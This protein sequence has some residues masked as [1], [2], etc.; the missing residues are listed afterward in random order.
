AFDILAPEIRDEFNLGFQGLLTIIAVVAAASLALQVPIAGFADRHSRV[1]LAIV[2]AL[3]WSVFSFSTGLAGGI[4]FLAFA[5]SGSAIG[6]AV[7]DPT[8]NSLLAD[9]FPPGDRPRVFAFHR[10]ANPVGATIGALAAGLLAYYFGWRAPFFVLAVPTLILVFLALRLREPIRGAQERKAIGADEEAIYIEE[11]PPSYSEGWRMAWKIGVLRRIFASMPFLTIAFVGFNSLNILFLEEIF[12]LDVRERA[13]FTAT[14]APLSIIGLVIGARISGRLIEKDPGLV[15]RFLALTSVVIGGLAAV[16]AL[17]LNLVMAFVSAALIIIF[18]AIL[19]PGILVVLSMAAPPRAR[20]MVFSISSLWILPGLL[21]LPLVGWI[22]D[23]WGIRYGMIT[24]LPIGLIGGL[25]LASAGPII[26]GDI[27]DVWQT[28]AARSEVLLAR[29]KGEEKVIMCKGLNAGYG[30]VQVLFDI[31]FEVE[32]GQIVALLGTNGA[33]KSTLLKVISGIVEADTGAVLLDGRD[34]THAPPNEI[35][36]HGV[37]QLPGGAGIF[38]SL[39][40]AE[41]LRAAS[42]LNR[43]SASKN[44][45]EYHKEALKNFPILASR[46]EEEAGNLSGG[47][48]QILG[49]AMAFLSRPRLLMIDELSLGLAPVIVEELLPKLQTLAKEGVTIVLVEQSVN[50]AL[51]VADT[52]YFMEKGEIKFHGETSELLERPDVL[53][54]V[55]LE[56]ASAGLDRAQKEVE[57]LSEAHVE[58]EEPVKSSSESGSASVLEVSG[59]SRSFGGISAVNDVS[60][61]VYAKEILGFIGP[62]GAGKTTLFDLIGG[63]TEADKGKVALSGRSIHHLTAA[64][65]SLRGLGRSFQDARLFPALTVE[66]TI[67]VALDR[68]TTSQDPVS[69]A[70]HLPNAFDSNRKVAARVNELI[71]LMNLGAFRTKFIHELSTGTRRIVDLAM[72][73]A[74]RPIVVLLDEPSSG[75]AQREAEALGP[76]LER[77]RDEMGCALVIIEHDISLL[78]SVADRMIAL[79]QGALIAE[80]DP[81]LVLSHPTVVSS[82]LGTDQAVI[83]R[84]GVQRN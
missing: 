34:I 16:Y 30:N 17:S 82:Y 71:E 1:R 40:V 15:L 57:N 46:L 72:V 36:A 73:V 4:I 76:V 18:G 59:I 65:R 67:A 11:Q 9:W 62:N 48:Q 2:G 27:K 44:W 35:A 74:H 5:R 78:R 80:G 37:T 47:Q 45:D 75:I 49:L 84:S 43:K 77:L 25:I 41:N 32:A 70:L 31:D 3:A 29:R 79:D 28:A 50:V 33:G 42:W 69:S 10:A 19:G 22:A 55:F 61:E 68:W 51:T 60:F 21:I 8:H 7:N 64:N 83:N 54:S 58:I 52:A 39:T 63:F 56:G 66:E 81:A 20:S 14:L 12:N 38:P 6:K 26:G 53:R 23:T 24:L 13:L